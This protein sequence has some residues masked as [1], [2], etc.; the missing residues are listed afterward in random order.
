M[1]AGMQNDLTSWKPD[2]F[3]GLN[4]PPFRRTGILDNITQSIGNTP[5]V[6]LRNV[7]EGCVATVAAKVENMN[8][9]WSIKDRISRAMI[10]AAERDGLINDDTVILEPTSGNTGIGLAYVCAARGYRLMVTL[11]ES[12]TIERRRLLRAL[13]A[14]IVLTPASDGMV[15]AVREA[16]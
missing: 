12:M 13:G 10:E 3:R 9:L 16:S 15:G 6:K 5:L 11:P 4:M 2:H 8:P 14:E 1:A 7:T